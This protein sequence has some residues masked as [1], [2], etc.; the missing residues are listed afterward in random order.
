MLK[1]A[2]I[3]GY[4][5]FREFSIPILRRINLFV[6]LNNSGK[7]ALL[8]AMQLAT[9][10]AD[11]LSCLL[12]CVQRRGEIATVESDL[13][14]RRTE[15]ELAHLF[16]GHILRPGTQFT[17]QGTTIENGRKE[18]LCRID[19]PGSRPVFQ[20]ELFEDELEQ[21]PRSVLHL[22]TPEMT[23]PLEIGLT[24]RGTVSPDSLRR[25]TSALGGLEGN[26]TFLPTESLNERDFGRYWKEIAL[27]RGEEDVLRAMQ[28][29]DPGVERWAWVGDSY[30]GYRSQSRG[31]VMLKHRDFPERIPIGSMGD[32][33]WRIASLAIGLS[34]SV[35][36]YLFIDE[37][38]TGLHYTAMESMWNMLLQI[39]RELSVQVFATTHS[40]DCV[41]SLAS[42]CTEHDETEVSLQRLETD[43]S[44]PVIYSE[45]EI[46]M[47]AQKGIETR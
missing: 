43:R 41:A 11:P 36:G 29:L 15:F 42:I 4:R 12:T 20:P 22:E 10:S 21:S 30:S 23:E 37:I 44:E 6:G 14:R 35:N 1:Q 38:D 26:S 40:H 18:L 24:A 17:I 45:Q 34:E 47:A 8:E 2:K 19:E 3:V 27:K 5:S 25:L 7:T 33:M 9:G 16:S 32:G 39:S 28:I 13:N 31:G 46:I